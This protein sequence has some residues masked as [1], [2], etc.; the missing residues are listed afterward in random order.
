MAFDAG[1][2]CGFYDPAC[3]TL[4]NYNLMDCKI[5]FYF[6]QCLRRWI[7]ERQNIHILNSGKYFSAMVAAAVSLTYKYKK[8]TGWAVGFV[9]CS[10][11]AT[12]Y[13][14]YWDFIV[15]WGLLKTDSKNFLLRDRLML[16]D[17]RIYF[18]S[19]VGLI[20]SSFFS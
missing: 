7:D 11:M 1:A 18:V 9:I 13:Q 10:T 3:T 6:F 20:L 16:Q 19:M 8:G 15:D 2:A 12:G 5:L 14:L 4:Q 17:K